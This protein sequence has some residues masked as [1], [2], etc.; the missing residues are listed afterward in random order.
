[1]MVTVVNCVIDVIGQSSLQEKYS[2]A[3]PQAS[4]TD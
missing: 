2:N 4:S 3:I 1:M